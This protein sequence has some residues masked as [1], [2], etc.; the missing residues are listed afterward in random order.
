MNEEGTLQVILQHIEDIS[1][2]V[3]ELKS[4]QDVAARDSRE[5]A[6]KLER[7]LGRIDELSRLVD[8]PNG[9][10]QTTDDLKMRVKLMEDA[11]AHRPCVV[12]NH[13]ERIT[14]LESYQSRFATAIF[15]VV[16][17]TQVVWYF[18]KDLL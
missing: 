10:K 14:K 3:R 9:V 8:G 2:T 1:R 11:I 12:E 18:G 13:G 6:I 5:A 7:V 17:V 15:A 4:A 16:L